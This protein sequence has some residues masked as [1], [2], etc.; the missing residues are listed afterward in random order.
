MNRK[1]PVQPLRQYDAYKQARIATLLMAVVPS[2][3]LFFIGTMKSV[4]Q[5]AG[6]PVYAELVIYGSTLVIAFSGYRILRKYSANIIKLRNQI[7]KLAEGTLPRKFVLEQTICSDDLKFIENNLNAILSQMNDRLDLIKEKLRIESGLREEIQEQQRTL[8]Q[9]E[10]HR[11]MLQSISAACHHPGQPASRLKTRLLQLKKEAHSI[12]ELNETESLLREV[13]EISNVL[14]R[15][16]EV[17]EFRTEPYTA[18]VSLDESLV[19][20]I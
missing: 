12:D 3:S 6:L 11:V 17:N 15:M 13:E 14:Q 5:R 16:R 20:A 18:V 1:N 4:E 2:L 7:Q 9:A 19:L 8:L 10:R